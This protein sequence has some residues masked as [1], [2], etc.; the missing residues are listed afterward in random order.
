MW[1]SKALIT[2]V[3]Y[4][5]FISYSFCLW[6]DNLQCKL[7]N[8]NGLREIRA[9]MAAAAA[10]AGGAAE[11]LRVRGA[12]PSTEFGRRQASAPSPGPEIIPAFLEP[13]FQMPTMP[14]HTTRFE[15]FIRR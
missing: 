3:F 8:S 9:T 14:K 4:L 12:R 6:V 2:M 15:F 7:T 1:V 11:A 5:G 13:H 10:D